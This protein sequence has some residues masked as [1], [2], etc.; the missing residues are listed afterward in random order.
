MTRQDA[1]LAAIGLL[2][3]PGHADEVADVDQLLQVAAQGFSNLKL[4]FVKKII[5]A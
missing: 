5:F 4:S 1:D 2:D 3:V